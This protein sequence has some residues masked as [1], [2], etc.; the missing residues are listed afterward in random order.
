MIRLYVFC[1]KLEG[2]FQG[3][4]ALE[5]K[6]WNTP[7]EITLQS[8]KWR[9]PDHIREHRRMDAGECSNGSNGG[10]GGGNNGRMEADG[11][12]GDQYMNIMK[13]RDEVVS[14][15]DNIL[16]AAWLQL[17]SLLGHEPGR[18]GV[19][20]VVKSWGIYPTSA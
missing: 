2:H 20:V 6:T 1:S 4:L 8:R 7:T 16:D 15:E 9:S 17:V 12:D 11:F 19:L 14:G 18:L 3:T 5:L 10:R 13:W